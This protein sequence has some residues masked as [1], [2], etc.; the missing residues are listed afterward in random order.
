VVVDLVLDG[1]RLLAGSSGEE[2]H[3]EAEFE[4]GSSPFVRYKL[5]DVR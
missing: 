5:Y 4:V 2:P 3:G 1:D